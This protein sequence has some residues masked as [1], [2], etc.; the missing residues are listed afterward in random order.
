MKTIE[1]RVGADGVLMLP[2]GV[3]LPD[4]ARLVVLA[5]EPNDPSA[6]DIARLAETSGAFDFL[7]QE[8]ELYSDRDILPGR[9][10]PRF[11]K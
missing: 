10:N 8:P 2:Q 6:L 5:L 7:A 1:V 4:Q 3:S 9:A 11:R